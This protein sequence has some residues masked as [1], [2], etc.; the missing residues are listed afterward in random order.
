M[1]RIALDAQTFYKDE[2]TSMLELKRK[3]D[4]LDSNSKVYIK[5]DYTRHHKPRI[6]I[7]DEGSL[8][9]DW[10]VINSGEIRLVGFTA[11]DGGRVPDICFQVVPFLS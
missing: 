4:S 7:L 8:P 9:F 1:A 2:I 11:G 3:S 5:M 6:S 10:Q